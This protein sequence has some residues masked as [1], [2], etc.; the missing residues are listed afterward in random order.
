MK[1]GKSLFWAAFL[2][3]LICLDGAQ[4][5][6]QNHPFPGLFIFL[7]QQYESPS[8]TV[9][10]VKEVSR[11]RIL[12]TG[13]EVPFRLGQYLWV[14]E[15]RE[16]ISPPL[17]RQVAWVQVEAILPHGFLARIIQNVGRAVKVQDWVLT[18]PAPSI[19][20]YTNIRA[21]HRFSAYQDLLKALLKTRFIIYEVEGDSITGKPDVADLLLRLEGEGDHLICRL[22]SLS[23]GQIFFTETLLQEDRI[24]TLFPLGHPVK[25][26]AYGSGEAVTSFDA[27]AAPRGAFSHPGIGARSFHGPTQEV[28]GD[29]FRISG[30][31]FR[32]VKC[33]LEGDG[34]AEIALLGKVDLRV[35]QADKARLVEKARYLINK[36]EYFPLHL[37]AKDL[38]GDGGDELLITLS[39]PV[40]YLDRLDNR[41]C[42]QVI[43]F[44][45][46][47]FQ[48][49]VQDWPYYL[50]V[51]QDREGR[52]VA[53]AQAEGKFKQYSGPIYRV[54]WSTQDKG[55]QLGPP[56]EPAR[57][58]YSIYQFAL[59]PG[60]RERVMILEPN[61]VLHGYFAPEERVE[62]SGERTYGAYTEISYPLK[63]ETVQYL[64]G[65]DRKKT[66]RE[67]FAPR[68]LE[69]RTEFDGQF[70]LLYKERGREALEKSLKKV[71]R[72]GEGFDQV[73]GVKWQGNRIIE[74]WKSKKLAKDILDF[75]FLKNPDRILVLYRDSDGYA[76]E[77]FY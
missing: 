67:V 22:S 3:V 68:R 24:D 2:G 61:H 70:F 62:A 27:A 34:R 75:T 20:L 6:A 5:Q 73:V 4:I 51:I 42:S 56:Y 54:R 48:V 41:L 17:Q 16:G 26:R 15:H 11:E 66:F 12:V 76:L 38:D 53:L 21:K 52:P 1:T 8:R 9:G 18:P 19:Y 29:F 65:F 71:L 13:G 63:L 23:S 64:G 47:N 33:D 37:H 58:I 30:A 25:M 40:Y 7:K 74:T 55:V 32:V 46:G 43:T 45:E 10:R 77:A 49:L 39:E 59:V 69:L 14:S 44:K 35:Y 31:Y 28:R 57:A 36:K 50:R 72:S 60:E